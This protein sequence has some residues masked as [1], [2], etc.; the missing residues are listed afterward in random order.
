MAGSEVGAASGGAWVVSSES[1]L[2]GARVGSRSDGAGCD[3]DE[4]GLRAVRV[5]FS[6]TEASAVASVDPA[7]AFSMCTVHG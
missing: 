4:V 3:G 7:D 1:A 2:V 5:S 6:G